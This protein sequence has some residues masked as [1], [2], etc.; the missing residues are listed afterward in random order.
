M[1][2]I[3]LNGRK[4]V[5]TGGA[6]GIGYSIAERLLA[7]GA[8]C[9]LWDRDTAAL[10]SAAKTLSGKGRVHTCT[11]SLDQPDSVAAA[12][13]QTIKALGAVDIL[14]NN[15]GIAGAT[16]KTWEL[17]PREWMLVIE[18]NLF[19]VYLCCHSLIPHMIDRE[20]GRIVNI[21]SIAGKEGNPNASH[22]S[23]AKA[24]VIALTKSLGKELATSGILVNC[25]TPAVI[26]TDILKQ[27]TQQHIDYM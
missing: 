16:K 8:A 13:E 23:A 25:V 21:A 22:Y 5:V 10:E 26:Q 18:T 27:V 17:T 7:S 4:A 2:Q 15:A 6:R 3:D 14:V 9:S 11:V 20:Y 12:A 24:G 1:N 19:G